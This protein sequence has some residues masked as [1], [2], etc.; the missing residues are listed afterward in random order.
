MI[1]EF[2]FT[3]GTF[4][5]QYTLGSNLE[6]G[7]QVCMCKSKTTGEQ[8]AVK[9]INRTFCDQTMKDNIMNEARVMNALDHPNIVHIHEFYESENEYAIVMDMCRGGELY[10]A[11]IKSKHYGEDEARIIIKNYLQCMNYCH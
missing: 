4:E 5:D 9:F 10:D 1:P 3:P 6:K 8:R 2:K 11:I 7:G